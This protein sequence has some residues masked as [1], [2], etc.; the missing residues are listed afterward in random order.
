[1]LGAPEATDVVAMGEAKAIMEKIR[2]EVPSPRVTPL[3]PLR[4]VRA[5][6]GGYV[7]DL[8]EDPEVERE[9]NKQLFLSLRKASQ[10]S[11]VST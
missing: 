4:T 5:V 3:H 10:L 8:E 7:G 1:M 2:R 9:K 11:R 6:A